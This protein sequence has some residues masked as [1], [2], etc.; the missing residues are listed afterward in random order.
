MLAVDV[1]NHAVL[2]NHVLSTPSR[3][4]GYH[5]CADLS[6]ARIWLAIRVERE[7]LKFLDVVQDLEGQI[8]RASGGFDSA[9]VSGRA[10]TIPVYAGPRASSRFGNLLI[11]A[12]CRARMR[13]NGSLK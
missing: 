6:L 4:T 2:A 9:I 12:S 8:L 11:H 1:N 10:L 13:L 3:C 5:D 7:V